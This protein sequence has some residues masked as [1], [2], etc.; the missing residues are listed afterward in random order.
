MRDSNIL[1]IC[2]SGYFLDLDISVDQLQIKLV[3][4]SVEN[5]PFWPALEALSC[6]N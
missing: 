6:W 5:N 1:R 4:E 3:I 2:A